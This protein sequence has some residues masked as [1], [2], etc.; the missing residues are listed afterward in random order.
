MV[1]SKICI[2]TKTE[3][4]L[5]KVCCELCKPEYAEEIENIQ[6]NPKLKLANIPTKKI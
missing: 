4:G 6:N 1:E 2:K 5:E 3:T